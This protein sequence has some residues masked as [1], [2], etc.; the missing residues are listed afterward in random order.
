MKP[1][2]LVKLLKR[3]GFVERKTKSG[4]AFFFHNDGRTTTVPIHNKPLFKGTLR[5]ILRQV[6]MSVE[7]LADKL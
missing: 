6:E 2:E 7:K 4:H 1:K 3:E 5:G